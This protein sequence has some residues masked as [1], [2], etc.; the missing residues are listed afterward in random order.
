MRRIVSAI[1][2]HVRAV[3]IT[4][5]LGIAL[6][7]SPSARSQTFS[8]V[9]SFTGGTDGGNP[10]SGLVLAPSGNFYG[11]TSSAG[12]F[13]AGTIYE[14][15]PAGTLTT[16]Y[17]FTG[18]ADGGTP[19]GS[20]ML[21]GSNLF[22][23]AS[24][25]GAHGAGAVFEVSLAGKETVLYSF[26]GGTADGSAPGAALTRDGVGNLYSTTFSG[27]TNDNG[28]VFELIRPPVGSTTWTEKILYSFGPPD[29][30]A[31]P[32]SGV[33]FDRAGNIYG[34]TSVGGQYSYG[35]VYEL[36]KSGTTYTEEILHQFALLS[37]GG[38]PYAGITVNKSTGVLYGATTDG[39][40]GGQNGGG[41][42]F[43][44]TKTNGT[45]NFTVLYSL[46]GW[47]ISGSF[48]NLLLAST[49]TLYGTT[50]CDGTAND[51]TVFELTNSGGV[52]KYTLLYTFTGGSNGYYLF[53]NPILDRSGNI[54]GTTRFGGQL[55]Y[56]VLF[57]IVP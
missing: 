56:G 27:G 51:G 3:A 44:M 39:G 47:G 10:Q 31:N 49:G 36:V 8:V 53:S 38:T 2:D 18:A 16:L 34:T 52:W 6:L 33:A 1:H 29:D 42:I 17:N 11:T 32:V 48:R 30:G 7:A 45:W 43:E 55:G 57:K 50:H 15:T 19:T 54:Y 41:T 21:L 14:L 13:G 12:E 25:G 37:D 20:L 40:Q 22:G 35:N 5:A 24:A 28:T 4:A 26:K 9:H 23:T 46:P